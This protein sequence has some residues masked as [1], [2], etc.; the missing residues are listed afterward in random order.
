MPINKTR[1]I[2]IETPSTFLVLIVLYN[3]GI[4][5]DVVKMAA[6]IPIVSIKR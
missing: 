3:C 6:I 5:P 2:E 4:N 1:N